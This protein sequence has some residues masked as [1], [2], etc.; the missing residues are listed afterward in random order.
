M[1]QQRQEAQLALHCA[2]EEAQELRLAKEGA[3]VE[4]EQVAVRCERR[5]QA[6]EVCVVG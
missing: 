2:R 6:H 1:T 4:K 5:G 3:V